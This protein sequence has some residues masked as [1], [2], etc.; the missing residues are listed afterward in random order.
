MPEAV[1]T[2]STLAAS[3][4]EPP[5]SLILLC[6]SHGQLMAPRVVQEGSS[7]ICVCSTVAV[8]GW[9]SLIFSNMNLEHSIS[10]SRLPHWSKPQAHWNMGKMGK[11]K[12]FNCLITKSLWLSYFSFFS[13]QRTACQL[14]QRCLHSYVNRKLRS[15]T[16]QSSFQS[17]WECALRLKLQ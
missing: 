14:T 7:L 12:L 10:H 8:W 2:T 5:L 15:K 9:D 6:R 13:L 1:R 3:P 17:Y 4:H 16:L 11:Q